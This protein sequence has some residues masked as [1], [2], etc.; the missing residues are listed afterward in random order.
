MKKL[1]LNNFLIIL[2]SI[3]CIIGVAALA[4]GK[5]MTVLDFF[6]NMPPSIM[7]ERWRYSKEDLALCREYPRTK[8][9]D[10]CSINVDI[11]NDYIETMT[12]AIQ[13]SQFAIWRYKNDHLIGMNRNGYEPRFYRFK[14][15]GVRD[16]TA[17]EFPSNK[18]IQDCMRKSVNMKDLIQNLDELDLLNETEV[19]F[20][21]RGTT[22]EFIDSGVFCQVYWKNGKFFTQP[23]KSYL[24]NNFV[25]RSVFYDMRR[26]NKAICP[27]VTCIIQR[28]SLKSET[29]YSESFTHKKP[30]KYSMTFQVAEGFLKSALFSSEENRRGN[31]EK[32]PP[33]ALFLDYVADAKTSDAEL[34]KCLTSKERFILS[35]RSGALNKSIRFQCFL[36]NGGAIRNVLLLP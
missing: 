16:V 20:P 23:T 34:S 22:I 12:S 9:V 32:R 18:S 14:S 27:D 17:I 19:V 29:N 1:G 15:N 5:E 33:L 11:A 24:L 8:A 4:K 3:L 21:K 31:L 28:S 10:K 25:S 26:N 7:Q 36:S 30:Q 13:P 6:V 2:F 35:A